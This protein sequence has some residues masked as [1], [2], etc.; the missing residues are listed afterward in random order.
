MARSSISLGLVILMSS[1]AISAAFEDPPKGQAAVDWQSEPAALLKRLKDRDADLD[2]R[3]VETEQHWVEK[4]SPRA[5]I[6]ANRFDARRFGQPDPGSPPEDTIP[7]DF[8]QP[9]RLRRLLT[10][11]EP[12]VTIERLNDLETMKHPEYVAIPNR[13]CRWSS[14]G[15]VERVWSPETNDLH[16]LGTPADDGLLRWDAHM[17]QW[18]SG[19]GL[20]R[21]IESIDSVKVKDGTLT[22]KGRMRLMGYDVSR[23]ELTLDR[24]L[25]VRRMVLSVTGKDGGG[26]NDYVVETRGTVRPVGCPPVAES[27]RF[28][29]VVKPEGKPESVYQDYEFRFV[30]ASARLTD[31]EYDRVTRIEPVPKALTIDTRQKK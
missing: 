25:I 1:P 12:A 27:G 8:D 3:S 16:I 11:R 18:S 14:A 20:A 23:V 9:H 29:R 2:N 7:A 5:Q 17:L 24:D 22:A 30:A 28:R 19:Y 4:V 10:V 21:W 26:S 6:A 13:S 31:E 15:G